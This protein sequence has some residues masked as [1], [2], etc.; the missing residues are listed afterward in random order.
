MW[1]DGYAFH[2]HA[3]H[4]CLSFSALYLFPL[5][6][7]WS[8]IATHLARTS[9]I[10]S[11]ICSG[12]RF[13]IDKGVINDMVL[14]SPFSEDEALPIIILEVLCALQRAWLRVG[15]ES[16]QGSLQV[17]HYSWGKALKDHAVTVFILLSSSTPVGI[18]L[19]IRGRTQGV[20][21]IRNGIIHEVV[22]CYFVWIRTVLSYLSQGSLGHA[23][24]IE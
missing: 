14:V 11:A 1:P 5:N 17:F 19:S 18:Y 2:Q 7:L 21:G 6:K 13:N 3:G 10:F 12:R 15:M 22:A 8:Y 24:K 9:L 16:L 4:F 20:E 23:K